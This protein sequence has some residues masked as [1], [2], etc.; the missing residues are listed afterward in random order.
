M[1]QDLAGVAD[2][3][4]I[5]FAI[6]LQRIDDRGYGSEGQVTGS[7]RRQFRIA[8]HRRGNGQDRLIGAGVEIGL[9]HDQPACACCFLVPAA[10]A[11]IVASGHRSVRTDGEAAVGRLAEVD[12][13]EIVQQYLLFQHLLEGSGGGVAGGQLRGLA[14][15]QMHAAFQPELDVAGSESAEL[16]EGDAGVVLDRLALAVVVEQ[17]ETGEDEDHH[18][19]SCEEDLP[20]EG[21]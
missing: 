18:E 10:F 6:E 8:Q 4:G 1:D 3:E 20:G 2:Q 17:D 15:D 12:R 13:F 16:G 5:A 11:R 7:H 19:G 14:L 9:G 21:E